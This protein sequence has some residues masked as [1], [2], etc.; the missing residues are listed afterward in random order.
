MFSVARLMLVQPARRSRLIAMLRIVAMTWGAEPVRTWE[1]LGWGCARYPTWTCS[2]PRTTTAPPPPP[3]SAYSSQRSHR[4]LH[5]T[6]PLLARRCRKPNRLRDG[7]AYDTSGR[8]VAAL[9][10]AADGSAASC[11]RTVAVVVVVR[12]WYWV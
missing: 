11:K 5:A 3:L 4:Q 10:E 1:R 7:S 2:P 8:A 6:Q 9:R 12:S